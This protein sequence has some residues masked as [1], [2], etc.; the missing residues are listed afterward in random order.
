[1]A[2]TALPLRL[3]AIVLLSSLLVGCG[4]DKPAVC[5]SVDALKTSVDD[6]KNIEISAVRA[7]KTARRS[8]PGQ[9]GPEQ[10]EERREDAVF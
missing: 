10:G 6:L 4:G 3:A 8:H 2:L 5:S 7:V 1:M 9:V